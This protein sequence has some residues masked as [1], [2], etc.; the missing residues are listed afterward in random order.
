MSCSGVAPEGRRPEPGDGGSGHAMDGVAQVGAGGETARDK[1][2]AAQPGRRFAIPPSQAGCWAENGKRGRGTPCGPGPRMCASSTS[3]RSKNRRRRRRRRG[4]TASGPDRAGA[5]VRVQDGGRAVGDQHR[6]ADL[7]APER[8]GARP[9]GCVAMPAPGV[10]QKSAMLERL[11]RTL[12]E[13]CVHRH[14]LQRQQHAVRAVADG[15]PFHHPG[16]RTRRWA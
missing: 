16:A 11:I 8:A 9:G 6:A 12:E 15:S 10:Q 14:R 4:R 13:P 2:T 5:V 3:G 7:P 1:A